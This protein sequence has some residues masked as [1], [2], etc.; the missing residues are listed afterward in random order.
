MEDD[1]DLYGETAN[2]QAVD[3][4]RPGKQDQMMAEPER[5]ES[6]SVGVSYVPD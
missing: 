5:D 6:D 4:Q 2:V 1:D 3:V